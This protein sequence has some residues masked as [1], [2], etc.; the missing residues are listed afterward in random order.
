[1]KSC[2]EELH[3][4]LSMRGN[5]SAEQA[6]CKGIFKQLRDFAV[7]KLHF[8]MKIYVDINLTDFLERLQNTPQLPTTS[9]TCV[10]MLCRMRHNTLLLFNKMLI[11]CPVFCNLA[12]FFFVFL[13]VLEK[14]L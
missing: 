3:T 14:R 8:L 13:L 6:E 7:K 12:D 4:F 5:I 1:M 10:K 9:F 11:S 2:F